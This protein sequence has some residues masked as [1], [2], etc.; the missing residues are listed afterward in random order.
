MKLRTQ[1]LVMTGVMAA[2]LAVL[3]P[4]SIPTPVGVPITLQTFLVALCGFVLGPRLG[5]AA[6]AVYLAL[7]AVGLPVFAEFSSGAACFL[8]M[9]GGF[10]WGFLFMAF[11]CGVGM[12]C[13]KPIPAIL[14]GVAGLVI[15]HLCGTIQFSLVTSNSLF[16][17]F[18][19]ASAPYFLKDAVFT[20]VAYFASRAVK[21][22]L[23]KARLVAE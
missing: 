18:L 2:L 20:A 9:T 7:G 11:L 14:L 15:C 19:L 17:A 1:K 13:E 22:A 8:G 6:V 4:V 16:Q 10:L 21:A 23:K 12:R 3:S 5:T